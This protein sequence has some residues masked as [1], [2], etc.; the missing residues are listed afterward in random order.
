IPPFETIIL[1]LERLC[2]IIYSVAFLLFM[3]LLGTYVYLM[4]LVVIPMAIVIFLF[5]AKDQNTLSMLN[6]YSNIA[7]LFGLLGVT[8]FLSMGYFRRFKLIAIIYW[9]FYKFFNALTLARYYRPTYFAM[10]TNFNRWWLFAFLGVFV[11][12]SSVGI[13][14]FQ[15]NS[16]NIFFSRIDIW[17][18]DRG[19][20][21]YEGFY[22]DHQSARPS[23][24]LQ[25]SSEVVK[26]DVMKVFI[27]L[28]VGMEDSLKRFI[29]YDSIDTISS[30]SFNR[31]QYFL[32]KLGEF[33][34][35]SIG[36]STF[37]TKGYF[38]SAPA[39]RQKGYITYLNVGYLEEGFYELRLEGPSGMFSNPF[40]VVPFYKLD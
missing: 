19:V 20:F 8:D 1:K 3:S 36:D 14:S 9:P 10:V 33:Y 25:I 28:R 40:A 38:Q 31:G 18:S 5:D 34:R 35:L 15:L 22:Q 27:P 12:L 17:S 16:P 23:T 39:T 24:N 26:D 7:M 37:S 11:V 13:T 32:D 29:A 21:A 6:T 4:V 2:S 30:S